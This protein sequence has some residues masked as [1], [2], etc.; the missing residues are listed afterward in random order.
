MELAATG[1]PPVRSA[2]VGGSHVRARAAGLIGGGN[3]HP[4]WLEPELG[5]VAGRTG[6]PWGVGLL[7]WAVEPTTVERVLEHEPAAVML[8]FGHGAR[9]G[10]R[11]T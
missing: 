5:I 8:S 11:W 4:K 6:K 2:G 7:S 1:G 9:P 3:G 10:S